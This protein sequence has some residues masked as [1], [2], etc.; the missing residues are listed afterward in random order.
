MRHQTAQPQQLHQPTETTP[1]KRTV[2]KITEANSGKDVTSE[3]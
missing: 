1:K 3:I 2:I